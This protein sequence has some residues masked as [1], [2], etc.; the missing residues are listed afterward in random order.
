MTANQKYVATAT[1]MSLDQDVWVCE[2]KCL[3]WIDPSGRKTVR[4]AD[5]TPNNQLS[6]ILRIW[7]S[8]SCWPPSQPAG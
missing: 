7:F 6:K 5:R 3:D 4:Y 8:H 2:A 1:G